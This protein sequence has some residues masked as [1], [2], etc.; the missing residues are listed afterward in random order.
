MTKTKI[1]HLLCVAKIQVWTSLGA[2]WDIQDMTIL[3]GMR[4][5]SLLSF[6]PQSL[7]GCF[8]N[9][10]GDAKGTYLRL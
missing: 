5:T 1:Q 3:P 2:I 4:D 8:R 9:G 10:K 6:M 7:W